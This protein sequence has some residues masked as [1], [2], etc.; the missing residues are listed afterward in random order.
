MK[1][2]SVKKLAV[3]IS[4]IMGLTLVAHAA[5]YFTNGVPVAGGSQYPTTLPLTGNETIPADTNLTAGQ[6][7]ASEAITTNQLAGFAG[8]L[9]ADNSLGN[10]L[11][12]GDATNN[13]FQRGTTGASVTTTVTYGGPD[14]W[15]YWSG[16]STAMTVSR[17]S[18]A[19]DLPAVGYQ[20]AF[21]MARTSGQTGLVQMC[22]AQ[23]V[24]SQISYSLQSQVV[25]LDFHATAGGNYSPANSLLQVYVISGTGADE[26]MSKLAFGL[27][28]GGGGSSGW[29]GQANAL[30]GSVAI[31]TTN[32]RYT[33]VATIPAGATE[34]GVAVCM[35]PVGTAGT[36]DYVALSGIQLVRNSS[37][38]GLAGTVSASTNVAAKPFSRRP[39]GVETLLQQRY[40]YQLTETAAITP[41]APCAA[42]D[43]THTNCLVQFPVSMR[44]TPT[45]TYA[46]GF[47]SPTSTTQATLG[48]CTTLA[49]AATVTSTVAN[50]LNVLVNC[51]AT[52]IPAAGVASFLY[53][54]NGTGK[55]NV[56]AEL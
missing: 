32:N 6:N 28:A 27:N 50:P 38:A 31:S 20:Y 1:K 18:T 39:Q 5:G 25:E 41:V 51:T 22:F 21:K 54:N 19:G 12:G 37:L 24:E 49:S 35:T 43:T 7:P 47:A 45:M 26:G 11:I 33:A 36:N 2:S 9:G 46:N 48:A 44:T 16:T 10:Y 15:A 29:T 3:G 56:S 55:I 30:A 52:T 13:L 34:V 42:V 8:S 4:A 17:D 40:Y 53:S 23:E 14:R